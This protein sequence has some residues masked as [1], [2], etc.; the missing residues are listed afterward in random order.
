MNGSLTAAEITAGA[1][2]AQALVLLLALVYAAK[3]L[4]E[5]R[6][7]RDATLRPFVVVDL[8][9]ETPPRI[10]ITITNLGPIMAQ[11]VRFAF[12]PPLA[13]SI[14]DNPTAGEL[15][16]FKDGLD[17]L[18]PGK[19]IRFQ[20]DYA[21]NR[22]AGNDLKPGLADRHDLTTTYRSALPTDGRGFEERTSLDLG[23]YLDTQ[24]SRKVTLNEIERQLKDLVK[25][26]SSWT[27]STPKGVRTVTPQAERTEAQRRQ[28]LREQQRSR[29]I[30]PE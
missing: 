10:D 23:L 28:A 15:R 20:F 29:A 25:V 26:L 4:A 22:W 5:A 14:Y 27:S 18:A 12:T 13:S 2:V 3:Q 30:P 19:Q 1:A 16:L 11:D 8:D 6:A 17:Y 7:T 21:T 9:A 24:Y